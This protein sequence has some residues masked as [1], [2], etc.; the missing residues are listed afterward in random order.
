MKG[1][2]GAKPAKRTQA[3]RGDSESQPQSPAASDERTARLDAKRPPSV[4]TV[5]GASP[6]QAPMVEALGSDAASAS[7][8][9][10]APNSPSVGGVAQAQTQTQ[11]RPSSAR[12]SL[13]MSRTSARLTRSTSTP[14][15]VGA[16]GATP[17]SGAGAGAGGSGSP[18]GLFRKRVTSGEYDA[19]RPGS[20]SP[21]GSSAG[22]VGSGSWD[23][24]RLVAGMM[25]SAPSSPLSASSGSGLLLASSSP[26]APFA[27][28]DECC[29]GAP[30][31]WFLVA[32]EDGTRY[33]ND[34]DASNV[35]PRRP[36]PPATI[37]NLLANDP[38]SRDR[39]VFALSRRGPSPTTYSYEHCSRLL[40]RN[41]DI[42]SAKTA[43]AHLARPAAGD[44]LDRSALKKTSDLL[45]AL[46]LDE[47]SSAF[48][49]ANVD[50]AACFF[51]SDAD[52]ARFGLR[53]G[54][55]VR[56]SLAMTQLRGT[57]S[58]VAAQHPWVVSSSSVLQLQ[59]ATE[60]E[61]VEDVEEEEDDEEPPPIPE[62]PPSPT[63]HS[64]AGKA[65]VATPTSGEFPQPSMSPPPPPCESTRTTSTL[66]PTPPPT[67]PPR[68]PPRLPSPAPLVTVVVDDFDVL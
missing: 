45:A 42:L 9:G 55:R 59:Q 23:L 15:V 49:A 61:D 16:G 48:G 28:L 20:P 12:L 58:A 63:S 24:S 11:T 64:A 4:A 32:T 5:T 13:S 40:S 30:S 37:I 21:P 43:A 19:A 65:S 60:E 41:S 67:K 47:F 18:L 38:E 62:L 39:A 31:L 50:L 46:G 3:E 8:M 56:W 52:L 27:P 7:P 22:R 10:S 6:Q 1:L 2:L 25:G 44:V 17:S 54:Q 14:S 34:C 57:A 29:V 66:V 33:V 35:S 26:A 53:M 36:P 68:P 51:L